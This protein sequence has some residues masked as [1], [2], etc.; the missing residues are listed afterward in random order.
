MGFGAKKM[1]REQP[2]LG[3]EHSGTDELGDERKYYSA[4]SLSSLCRVSDN[5]N[6]IY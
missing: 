2:Y 4:T 3:V 1:N 5:D 6:A